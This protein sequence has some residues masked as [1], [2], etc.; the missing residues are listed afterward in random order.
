MTQRIEDYAL[1]GDLQTAALVGKD[2]SID[3]LCLP[4]FDSAACFAALLGDED[5]GHWRVAPA[6][7]GACARRAYR[8]D[9]LVLDTIWETRSGSVKVTD[10]MPQRDEAPDVVRIVEGLSGEVTMRSTLRLRFDYGNIVPWM[11]RTSGHRVA[12]A[13]PDAVWL[14]AEPADRVK[15]WG[16]Q[17]TTYSSFTVA[18]GEKVAFVLTW[19]PSHEPEPPRTDPFEG[20]E[21]SVQDWQEWASKCRYEGP[22]REA[23]MRSLITLKAL[24]Y[25]PTGGIV[26]A[27]TT[28]LPEEIGGVRNWDYRYCWLR[29]STLTLG[30]LVAAG[31]IDE[32]ADW[33][34][35]LLRAVAGD[36]ADLQIMYGISGER[37]LPETELPWLKGYEGS[38]PVRTGNAAVKQLQLDVY[39]EVI[40]SLYMARAWGLRP[41][42]HAWN[43]QLSLLGFLESNWREPDEG[44]WEVRGP[45]R[46]FVHSKVMAWVAAD[47][48][49]RALEDDPTLRGDADRWRVMRDE[50]HREVC[51]K[52][53]DPE[54][55][56]FTQYYGSQELDAAT[57]LIPRV[58]FLPPDDPRVV[59][60]VEAVRA[61]LSHGGFI[62]RYS[63]DGLTV[64]GLPG[65][66]GTFL[67]CSF[68]LVDALRMTGRPKEARELFD[69]LLTLRSDVGLLAEEYDPASGR[70]LG[71]FPQAF[72][73][74]GLVV[75]ALGL[76]GGG[77]EAAGWAHG[78]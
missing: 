5:N 22:H 7:A 13:G 28:S 20:L 72:S 76:D 63:T 67:A 9:T 56:T 24:T 17:Y 6:G 8:D 16:Q 75:S 39:G 65:D 14:R 10:F 52:G 21:H 45:R 30:A 25:A 12:V 36:P 70:Q 32:A 48:A 27:P 53:Y 55:N 61:E 66:E 50:V 15:S 64:D 41:K 3:W 71:N 1:I 69:R 40:D 11:R 29:D 57:L 60:T 78:S 33:R 51:E 58:G 31:Y 35:W 46:H 54:R 4:R 2:G 49:V 23:V 44:L 59:G 62:R 43:L 26:A 34:D 38:A 37:R 47:R 18:E 73:H 19:H 68:W 77:D 74:I 42:P